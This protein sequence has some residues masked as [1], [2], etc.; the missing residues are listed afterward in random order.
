MHVLLIATRYDLTTSLSHE[1]ATRLHEQ[2]VRSKHICMLLTAEP[3]CRKGGVM[4]EAIDRADFV[5]FFGHGEVDS[6]TGMPRSPG[7][8]NV[9]VID[10]ATIGQLGTR[11]VYAGCCNSFAGLGPL[12]GGPYVGY[13]NPFEFE[14]FHHLE[15]GNIVVASVV[16]FVNGRAARAIAA[17]LKTRWNALSNDF[18]AGR[19]MGQPNAI[20]AGHCAD[21]NAARVRA[22]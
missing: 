3:L 16:D 10:A 11:S 15:F 17:D 18:A 22:N 1:W 2:L 20:M 7:V 21:A 12:H 13:D 9:S 8:G 4:T 14:T 5:V 6:W 19:L